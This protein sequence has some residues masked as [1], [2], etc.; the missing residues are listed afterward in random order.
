MIDRRRALL[1]CAGGG[2][3]DSLVASVVA[4]ALHTRYEQVDALTL[5]SHCA[6]LERVPDIDTVLA[7]SGDDEAALAENLRQRSYDACVV[8]WASARTARV[9]WR[10]GIGVRVGQASRLYS[11]RFTHRVPVRSERG[12]VTTH[13]SQILLDYARVLGCDTDDTHPR[14]VPTPADERAAEQLRAEVPGEPAPF[15]ILHPTNAIAPLRPAWPT[16]GWVRLARSLAQRYD[17]R[18]LVSGAPADREIAERIATA[19]GASSIAGRLGIGGFGAL[20]RRARAFVGIT[21]G[22][23]HVAAAVGAPTVGI[24]PFQSDVPD[25]WAPLGS[26][27]AVVRASF[28]CHASDTKE[29]CADYACIANLDIPRIIAAVDTCL[30]LAA[31]N[32]APLSGRSAAY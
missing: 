29:H 25:R 17:T 5:P 18:I 12:D 22:A 15:I 32:D 23:M 11:W 9:A 2:I 30:R 8:T 31:P 3:G 16:D 7:D 28:P 13:W 1:Y 26:A 27:T 20:A 24:F 6:T 10:S 19:G 14:F 4:R 21:T